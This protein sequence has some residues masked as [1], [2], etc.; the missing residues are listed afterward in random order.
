V[1]TLS[2]AEQ[3]E[4]LT[5]LALLE[6]SRSAPVRDLDMWAVGVE[7]ALQAAIGSRDGAGV[8][9]IPLKRMLGLRQNWA[10][11]ES[12]MKRHGWSELVVVQRSAA[13]A[14]L[15]DL[16]VQHVKGIA[17]H[18]HVP[19]T[20]KFVANNAQNIAAIFDQAF[21]GYAAS[22]LAHIVLP[23]MEHTK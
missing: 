1:S 18:I 10:P 22:G 4:L 7:T 14:L 8:G 6:Q 5:E 12:F 23:R 13:Y 15:A 17:R 2:E 20:A 3:R 16:L 9:L 21:P 11:V 19:M